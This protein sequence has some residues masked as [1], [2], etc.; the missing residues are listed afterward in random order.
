MHTYIARQPILQRDKKIYAYELLF[1]DGVANAFPEIDG[2]TAT[3]RLL[4]GS[5]MGGGIEQFTGDSLA[6]INFPREMIINNVAAGFSPD[7]VVIE[8]LEDVTPDEAVISACR[9]IRTQ[10]FGLALDDFF[11]Q[12]SFDPLLSL[13]TTIKIDLLQT[14]LETI[15]SL[16][17]DLRSRDNLTLLAEKVET[18]EQFQKAIGMGF[19]LFQGY[20]FSKPEVMKQRDLVPSKINYIRFIMEIN[21][22][23]VRFDKLE[24]V[25]TQDIAMSF[26]LFRYINSPYFRR[27]NEINSVR[28]AL[29]ILGEREIR[30]FISVIALSNLADEKPNELIKSAIFRARFCEL[31]G[32]NAASAGVKQETLFLVGLF[33]LIDAM[34]DNTMENIMHQLPF[35]EDI[36]TALVE[37]NGILGAYLNVATGCE[38]GDWS[39]C[40]PADPCLHIDE[41]QI[42]D[43]YFKAVQFADAYMG[44]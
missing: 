44:K 42:P 13:A 36:K 30:N 16:V 38:T 33:S 18:Y 29:T 24:N 1:R 31:I 20:F 43:D 41:K 19:S 15:S 4:M 22:A 2:N 3:S 10:E 6:F 37:R 12:P 9:H 25:I 5:L 26:K 23:N 28:H 35:S 40:L 32:R 11:Y 17:Q 8:V 27:I 14:P 7:Q 39:S 34:L 21:K